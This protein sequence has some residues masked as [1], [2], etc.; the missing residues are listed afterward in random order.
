MRSRPDLLPV[1][2]GPW[3]F[4]RKGEVPPGKQGFFEIPV[5]NFHEVG[6]WGVGGGVEARWEALLELLQAGR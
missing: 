4:D 2:T 5:L 3:Y 1:L 6:G